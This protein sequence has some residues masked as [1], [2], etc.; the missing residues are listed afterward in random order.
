MKYSMFKHI[1]FP[2]MFGGAGGAESRILGW[3]HLPMLANLNFTS[4]VT[5]HESQ[6]NSI[7]LFL[8]LQANIEG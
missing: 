7:Y 8:E 4:P 1:G 3:V 6:C 5:C 2:N